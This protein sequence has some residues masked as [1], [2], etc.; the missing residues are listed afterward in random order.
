MLQACQNIGTQAH[1]AGVLAAALRK[2]GK[3][4][5]RCYRCGL[6]DTGADVTVIRDPEWPVGWPTVP[7]KELWGIGGSKPGRQSLS[8]VTVSKPGGCVLA[9]IRPFVLPVHLN[10]WGRD[11]LTKLDTTL[12]I[13]I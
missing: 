9:T 13:N 4:G 10:I 12:N 2:S 11:L 6:V 1:K 7:S 3:E 5:K 8:W